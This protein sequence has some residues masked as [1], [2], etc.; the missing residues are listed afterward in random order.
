MVTSLTLS[1]ISCKSP[2]VRVIGLKDVFDAFFFFHGTT[3]SHGHGCLSLVDVIYGSVSPCS[4]S[5][6][7][8]VL[9]KGDFFPSH[10]SPLVFFCSASFTASRAAWALAFACSFLHFST[11][12]AIESFV[13]SF[14]CCVV[15]FS[16]ST[17]EPAR[18]HHSD[19]QDSRTM[20]IT[21][22]TAKYSGLC[23]VFVGSFHTLI[24]TWWNSS[25][26]SQKLCKLVYTLSDNHNLRLIPIQIFI[27][28]MNQNILLYFIHCMSL[29]THNKAYFTTFGRS[30]TTEGNWLSLGSSHRTS[31]IDNMI[32]AK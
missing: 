8:S 3:C 15:D 11:S 20:K 22:S 28:I 10:S 26:N 31:M 6:F 5:I 2:S 25:L 18:A 32:H 27:S 9:G 19:G 21:S 16:I 13:S 7:A 4:V 12:Y 24:K 17:A 30:N 29:A 14:L 1:L 23:H